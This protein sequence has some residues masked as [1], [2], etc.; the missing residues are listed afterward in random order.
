MSDSWSH[1]ALPFALVPPVT[2]LSA[3]LVVVPA[4]VL[5]EMVTL[6]PLAVVELAADRVSHS[7]E[8]ALGEVGDDE[9]STL[10]SAVPRNFW[11]L[12]VMGDEMDWTASCWV[13]FW[14][15]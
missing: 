10:I 12:L 8:A 1:V 2:V 15:R 6:M 3:F 13:V 7:L 4:A 14:R 9:A 11:A 5:S